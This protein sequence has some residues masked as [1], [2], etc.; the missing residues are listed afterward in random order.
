MKKLII[1]GRDAFFSW[2]YRH[3]LK[4]LFFLA[5]PEKIHD[6]MVRTG[7]VLGSNTLGRW[8]IKAMFYSSSPLLRQEVAGL[9]FESPVGLAAGFDKNV[10]LS[11]VLPFLGFGFAEYG[12]VTGEPCEGNPKPRLWRLKKSKGL[13]VYY[14]LKNDGAVVLAKRMAKEFPRQR[15]WKEARHFVNGVS[16]AKTNCAA[17]VDCQQ[18]VLDYAKAYREVRDYADY[19]TVNISCPNAYGG[20]PFTDRKSLELLLKEL[21]TLYVAGKPVFVKMS[22]DLKRE[23]VDE[24]IEVCG[25]HRV[26]GYICSNLT[27]KRENQKIVD[28][29]LPE[30]GGISGKVV[31]HLAD[32]LIRHVYQQTGGKKVIIGVGGIFSAE[33][34]YEKI[35]DGASLVQLITGMIFQGPSL[36]SQIN[37][38]LERLLKKDGYKHIAEAVGANLKSG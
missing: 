38:G 29:D 37:L 32:D 12:S 4:P 9:R 33:D 8:L 26:D 7:W 14:G 6:R 28:R 13:L 17:T 21:D 10:E 31:Q 34:A 2:G 27:K 35:K 11:A 1:G 36:I 3:L 16:V 19:I 23:E 25:R 15:R 5:D 20:Q 22:P 30:V 24:I 18:G